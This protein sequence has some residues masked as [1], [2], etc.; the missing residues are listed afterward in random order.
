MGLQ[1]KRLL[2]YMSVH[3]MGTGKRYKT[4]LI[5]FSALFGMI[6]IIMSIVNLITQQK[7]VLIA[8]SL[9]SFGCFLSFGI[10][11]Y[12]PKAY[13][14]AEGVFFTAVIMLF[15]FFLITGIP[16]GF[17][18]TWICLLPSCG[19]FIL[20][21]RKGLTLCTIQLVLIILILDTPLGTLLHGYDFSIFFRYRFPIL[22]VCMMATGFL[23]EFVRETNADEL[24]KEKEKYRKLSETDSLTNIPN[25][26]GLNNILESYLETAHLDRNAM[27]ES[28]QI[29]FIL[30]DINDFKQMNIQYGWKMADAVLQQAERVLA[31]L[32]PKDMGIA[33]SGGD[34]FAFVGFGH[35][36]CDF[37]NILCNR[38]CIY[39]KNNAIVV[40]GKEIQVSFTFGGCVSTETAAD[41]TLDTLW[42][43]VYTNYHSAKKN[44]IDFVI[45][46]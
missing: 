20:G 21:N 25:R 22:F 6:G 18:P 26:L 45:T 30:C 28:R 9:F 42:G 23:I 12:R 34:E 5:I 29:A 10:M 11:I 32:L 4:Q 14:V 31:S 8:T 16:G 44:G 27:V 36:S 46:H 24:D 43:I 7:I 37:V 41:D 1:K 38:I 33:R 39:F 15:T 35:Y 2:N 17:S 13:Q 3:L 19:M 40:D